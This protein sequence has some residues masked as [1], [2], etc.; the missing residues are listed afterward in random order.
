VAGRWGNRQILQ[1]DSRFEKGM[2]A[3]RECEGGG[4]EA[5]RYE[6]PAS[7]NASERK[8]I[9]YCQEIIHCSTF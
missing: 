1:Y 4:G 7:V 3:S 8:G 6:E 2:K 5:G 9:C